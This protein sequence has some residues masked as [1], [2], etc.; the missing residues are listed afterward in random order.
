MLEGPNAGT[1]EFYRTRHI[2]EP[3]PALRLFQA[4]ISA[5]PAL[6]IRVS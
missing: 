2:A 6:K 1:L 5:E 3:A 4:F